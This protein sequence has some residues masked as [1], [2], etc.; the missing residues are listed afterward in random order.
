LIL[1]DLTEQTLANLT[2]DHVDVVYF[3]HFPTQ[4]V[5]RNSII[6]KLSPKVL[7]LN[8]TKAEITSNSLNGQTSPKCFYLKRDGAVTTALLE[9]EL[10]IQSYC[11][12]EFRL[13][14]LSR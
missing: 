2:C 4:R 7:V 14:S 12:S 9:G 8:G 5:P 6:T 13:R 11:G 10:V 1:Q 3:A